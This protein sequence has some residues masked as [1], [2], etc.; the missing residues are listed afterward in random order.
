VSSRPCLSRQRATKRAPS[1]RSSGQRD[2]VSVPFARSR[3]DLRSTTEVFVRP[4][5]TGV[6]LPSPLLAVSL[7]VTSLNATSQSAGGCLREARRWDK[8]EYHREDH[9]TPQKSDHL[10]L[11]PSA[12]SHARSRGEQ[13][14]PARN[15]I[16]MSGLLCPPWAPLLPVRPGGFGTP[17]WQLYHSINTPL[18]RAFARPCRARSQSCRHRRASAR[19]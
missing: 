1:V 13:T 19:G 10:F 11:L 9:G 12:I 18:P 5:E 7:A 16:T 17:P 2:A 4:C 3:C 6:Q 8:N 15:T 14:A